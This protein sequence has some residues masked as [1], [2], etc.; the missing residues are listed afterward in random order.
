MTGRVRYLHRTR[1]PK[2]LSSLRTNLA[3]ID[4]R[5]IG[6]RYSVQ[7]RLE[8][9]GTIIVSAT[10]IFAIICSYLLAPL[11][12][13]QLGGYFNLDR[14]AALRSLLGTIGGALVGATAIGFSVVTVAV[15]LNF[16]RMPH[17][18]FIRLSSD[19]KLLGAFAGTFL[20]AVGV[21]TLS[22]I[23]DAEWVA[24][25]LITAAWGTL[26]IL[27]LF[28]YGYRRALSLINPAVQLR[29]LVTDAQKDLGRWARRADRIA[30]LLR[31]TAKGNDDD[32]RST[33]DFPRAVFYRSNPSWTN[34]A[35]RDIAHAV[36]FARRY[37]DQGDFEVSAH[38]LNSICT[39]NATYVAAKGRT[40]FAS[41]PLVEAPDSTDAFIND[42]LEHLRRLTHAA[43]ARDDEEPTRQVFAALALLVQ[44]YLSIDYGNQETKEHA[45][46]AAGYLTD[47]I[48][49]SVSGGSPDLLMEGV[50]FVGRSGGLFLTAGCPNDTTLL[51][52]K[53]AAFSITGAIKPEYRPVTL[54]GMDQLAQLTLDLLRVQKHDIGFAAG[55]LRNAV[56]MVSKMFLN[57]P[58]TPLLN[59][60]SSYLAPYFSLTKTQTLADK[61]TTLT[62]A[63][64][65]A[66]K[67]DAHAKSILRNFDEW[68]EEVYKTAKTLLL[69]SVE[70]RSNFAFDIVHW[71]QHITKLLVGLSRA[72]AADD[73]TREELEKNAVW[74]MSTLSWIPN[75]K[76]T[77]NFVENFSV[78]ELMFEMAIDAID[79]GSVPVSKCGRD[80]LVGWA[81]KA[82]A[83][84][85]GWRTLEKAL[86][87][88]TTI[89]LWREELGLASPLKL[90]ISKLLERTSIAQE[91]LDRT[92]RNLR[93]EA[94]FPRSR[95]YEFD[96]I[97]H[98][99]KQ[100]ERAK[101]GAL[102]IEIADMISPATANEEVRRRL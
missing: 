22:L 68:S 16:A 41:N 92:A 26:L 35:K 51:I 7:S 1:G 94:T 58:D 69:L 38:A 42:T 71:I 20:L 98:A 46:L 89:A 87:A 11:V 19:P 86:L 85:T 47:A 81:F 33:R 29:L 64:V 44:V 54:T 66:D 9:R 95:E 31:S 80:L 36:S 59:A 23:P 14:L 57:V 48:E 52:E 6:L 8:K 24:F 67:D 70:K 84:E 50:R 3:L 18:L 27:V 73:H 40:F 76:E 91:V 77:I 45:R 56:E 13:N 32:D 63:L 15:Q 5:L 30:P 65:A 96:R 43:T 53:I 60:H 102:L 74:L 83:Y 12:Q 49:K 97:H 37:A 100:L 101:V 61:L 93:Q 21:S 25:A 82:G 72:P 79:H 75:D 2:A 17:G 28:L 90:E 62:N 39:I 78:T 34:R 10:I 99:K 88:L 55:Q 4:I